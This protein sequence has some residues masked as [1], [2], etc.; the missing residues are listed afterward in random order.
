MPL[1]LGHGDFA[2]RNVLVDHGRIV[3]M[4]TRA[5]WR[6]PVFEDLAQM[7]VALRA[8]RPQLLSQGALFDGHGLRRLENALL[9]GYFGGSTVPRLEINL[10]IVL[11]LLDLWSAAVERR[12]VR[13]A[14]A[15]LG[16]LH[17]RAMDQL[18]RG[19]IHG[20]G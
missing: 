14:T 8:N 1:G 10:F 15:V 5:R 13:P 20:M 2:M 11:V 18:L 16:R 9:T 7:I 12:R 19:A 4:D 17:D 3:V 6:A